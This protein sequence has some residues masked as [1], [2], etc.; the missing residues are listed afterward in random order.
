MRSHRKKQSP[1]CS[2]PANFVGSIGSTSTRGRIK[3][4]IWKK[5][6]NQCLDLNGVVFVASQHLPKFVKVSMTYRWC[7]GAKSSTVESQLHPESCYR[8]PSSWTFVCRGEHIDDMKGRHRV[9]CAEKTTHAFN[10]CLRVG[11]K[12]PLS[13]V[14]TLS[15]NRF[16]TM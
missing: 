16:F 11:R 8:L 6:A 15:P 12:A 4:Y 2:F 9:H 1:S 3:K 5:Q 10:I 14:I 7:V 13:W